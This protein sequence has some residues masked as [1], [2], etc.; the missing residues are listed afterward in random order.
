MELQG[1]LSVHFCGPGARKQY[2]SYLTTCELSAAAARA[3]QKL[4]TRLSTNRR[5]LWEGILEDLLAELQGRQLQLWEG[6]KER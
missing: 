2:V 3:R 1:L 5:E 4:S 6:P